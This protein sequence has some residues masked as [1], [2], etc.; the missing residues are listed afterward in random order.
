MREPGYLGQYSKW[1]TGWTTPARSWDF[2]IFVTTS[3]PALGPILPPIQWV[4]GT[5][6]PGLKRPG[7]EG[8][9]PLPNTPSQ[10]GDQ[11]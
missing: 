11:L 3:R 5:L 4:S 1:A 7:R 9:P 6:S 10:H 2:F 8:V